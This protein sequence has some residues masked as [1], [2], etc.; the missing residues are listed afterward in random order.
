MVFVWEREVGADMLLGHCPQSLI[1][2][3][4]PKITSPSSVV[5]SEY[6]QTY[7]DP[8]TEKTIAA[9]SS[10]AMERETKRA[11]EG[12]SDPR[13]LSS[14]EVEIGQEHQDVP[15]DLAIPAHN[16]GVPLVIVGTK[17]DYF[18]RVLAK[19]GADEKFD[20]LMQRIRSVAIEY[21]ATTIFTSAIGEG[22]NIGVL[23]VLHKFLPPFDAV[24]VF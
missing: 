15:I 20:F 19:S 11:V 7:V 6:V 10:S 24:C 3:F 16:F 13:D 9:V 23:Q 1:D 5:V 12:S 21:G 4:R 18:S 17:A 22:S 8:G 2:T 14:E